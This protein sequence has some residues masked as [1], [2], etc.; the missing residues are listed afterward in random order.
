MPFLVDEGGDFGGFDFGATS[1][2]DVGVADLDALGGE[3]FVDGGFVFED[4]GFLG[5]VDDAHDVDVAE[6]RAAFA[7]VG[8]GHAVVAT[9]FTTGFDFAADGDGPVKE[10][11]EAGDALAR[12]GGFD[13]FEEG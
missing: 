7:P 2:E 1:P 6:F 5:A 12:V 9:D 4:F 10:T 3:V 13:V 11:V 8:V